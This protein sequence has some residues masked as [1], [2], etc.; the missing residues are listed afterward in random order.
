MVE[1]WLQ[2]I[3]DGKVHYEEIISVCDWDKYTPGLD[4]RTI[5]G[6][7]SEFDQKS[8]AADRKNGTC[9]GAVY[10]DHKEKNY[11]GETY[12]LKAE[13]Q[14]Y[15]SGW[16]AASQ[17]LSGFYNGAEGPYYKTIRL[18]CKSERIS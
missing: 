11:K 9:I 8:V 5:D 6:I 2:F 13:D 12:T 16:N 18:V 3:V 14:C 1:A 7:I 17:R 10:S 15:A 4:K